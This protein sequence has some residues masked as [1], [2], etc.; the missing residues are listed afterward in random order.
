MRPNRTGSYTRIPP[1]R[2]PY[3]C[4]ALC[5]MQRSTPCPRPSLPAPASG[6]PTPDVVRRVRRQSLLRA[7]ELMVF[8]ASDIKNVARSGCTAGTEESSFIN[9]ST[10]HYSKK[11]IWNFSLIIP[12]RFA[13]RRHGA[14]LPLTESADSLRPAGIFPARRPRRS[15]KKLYLDNHQPSRLDR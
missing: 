11:S 12:R 7:M 15:Q 8:V 4:P 14:I 1:G 3:S 13:Y 5:R 2:G 6:Q 10:I 9:L